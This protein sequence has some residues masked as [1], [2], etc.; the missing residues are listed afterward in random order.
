MAFEE[1]LARLE[2]LV[3]NLEEGRLTLEESLAAFG[4]GMALATRLG[5]LLK[6]AEQKV[7]AAT[8]AA[9]AP[10]LVPAPELQPGEGEG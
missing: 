9:G 8:A 6:E 3:R 1:D 4:E 10:H 7:M 5:D 2:E